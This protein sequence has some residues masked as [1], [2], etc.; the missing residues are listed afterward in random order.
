MSVSIFSIRFVRA[1]TKVWLSLIR[2]YASMSSASSILIL[3][4]HAW[5]SLLEHQGSGRIGGREGGDSL[6]LAL[7]FPFRES[8]LT[9][10]SSH[11]LYSGA[12]SY[13]WASGK[14]GSVGSGEE[15]MGSG[16]TIVNIRS[17]PLGVFGN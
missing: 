10:L 11:S 6:I 15:S 8:E 4:A 7:A 13:G 17:L 2:T 5:W 9:N 3:V 14:S 1:L 12:G 16:R